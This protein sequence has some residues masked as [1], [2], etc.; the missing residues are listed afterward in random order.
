MTAA[1]REREDAMREGIE[2]KGGIMPLE[3]IKDEAGRV[4]ALRVCECTMKGMTPLPVDGTEF[5]I[6][7]DMIIS[8]IGQMADLADGLERLDSGR[9]AIAIDPVF[10]VKTMPKHFAGGDVVRP[11]LLTTAIGHGRIAAETIGD[12][13]DGKLGER[14]P[15]ID[16]RHF[17]L[18]AELQHAR[19]RAGSLTTT[20]RRAA[21]RPAI[22]PSTI[23]RT[24]APRRS[25]RTRI[26]SRA[27]SPTC[28]ARERGGAPRRRPT[29]CSAISTN[30]SSASP[31][32]RRARRASA[33]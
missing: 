21:P 27:T 29:R 3:V 22:S 24:A 5:D 2:I 8:A 20:S 9:G 11:H 7:C 18:L 25:S 15:K 19:P 1:E 30:A 16:V 13:L 17:D 12:F 23:T 26:C 33:A 10:Q 32:S 28:R 4:T 6:P 31:R 14:R